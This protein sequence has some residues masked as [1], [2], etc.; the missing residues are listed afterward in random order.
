MAAD[1]HP[2]SNSCQGGAGRDPRLGTPGRI[3]TCT[4][5]PILNCAGAYRLAMWRQSGPAMMQSPEPSC[6][7][8]S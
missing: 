5:L 8:Y 6:P 4:A 2:E 7:A 1:S 3:V